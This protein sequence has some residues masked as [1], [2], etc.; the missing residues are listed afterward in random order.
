MTRSN[1]L[2]RSLENAAMRVFLSSVRLRGKNRPKAPEPTGPQR[3]LVCKWCCLG[4]AVVSLYA[5]REFKLRHPEIAVDMLVSARI[6]EVYRR[7]PF[8]GDVHVLPVTGRRLILELFNPGLWSRFAAL[9]LKLRRVRY[10]QF[11]DLEWYRGTG[12][13]L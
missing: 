10:A 9:M 8:I 11:I 12:P 2:I 3:I 1:A 5:L 7:A 4:D 13:V 6:A